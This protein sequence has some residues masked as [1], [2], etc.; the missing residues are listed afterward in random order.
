M[1]IN[2][3]S[4]SSNLTESLHTSPWAKTILY[5]GSTGSDINVVREQQDSASECDS[6]FAVIVGS[7]KGRSSESSENAI[8]ELESRREQ[9]EQCSQSV[10]LSRRP[11]ARFKPWAFESSL[12]NCK[13]DDEH[14]NYEGGLEQV[15]A[16]KITIWVQFLFSDIPAR[17]SAVASECLPQ[18][19]E[20]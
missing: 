3:P 19:W 12:M 16:K 18:L 7:Q 6:Q 1:A 17:T 5:V 2:S 8:D 20:C 13:R 15:T 10:P 14:E 9:P 11:C 4:A